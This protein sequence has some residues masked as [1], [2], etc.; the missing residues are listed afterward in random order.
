MLSVKYVMC[1][2]FHPMIISYGR[3]CWKS[4]SLIHVERCAQSNKN[5]F[6]NVLAC[7]LHW[8]VNQCFTISLSKLLSTFNFI[9][10]L[11]ENYI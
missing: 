1:K 6:I 5:V 9:T 7:N 10:F 3:H 4:N 11:K 2:L 8:P